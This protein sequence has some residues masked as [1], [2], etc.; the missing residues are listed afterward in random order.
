[1]RRLRVATSVAV[2]RANTAGIVGTASSVASGTK[3]KW[4]PFETDCCEHGQAGPSPS[5]ETGQH[6]AGASTGLFGAFSSGVQQPE[7]A[8]HSGQHACVSPPSGDV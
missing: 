1:M 4:K 5:G 2:S 6:G 8:S 3:T 7:P